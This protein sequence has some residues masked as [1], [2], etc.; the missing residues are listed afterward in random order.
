MDKDRE[1]GIR[2]EYRQ[3]DLR[4]GVR[5]KY[6]EEYMAGTN[7]VLL[8]PDVAEVFSDE[9]SVNEVL[10]VLIKAA[11]KLINRTERSQETE[12]TQDKS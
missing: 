6:Y 4:E 11:R 2:A 5:G 3:E 8:S 12:S 1:D 7:L 9:E 10:R